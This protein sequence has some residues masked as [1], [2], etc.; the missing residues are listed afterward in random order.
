MLRKFSNRFKTAKVP[1]LSF[2]GAVSRTKQAFKKDADINFIMKK[3]RETGLLPSVRDRKPFYGDFT[4]APDFLETQNRI[5][6][7]RQYFQQLPADVRDR[8]A[9]DPARMLDFLANPEN[10]AE[11]VKLGLK[12]A[13]KAPEAPVEPN[14]PAEKPV[15]AAVTPPVGQ[16]ST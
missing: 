7:T 5:A 3:Y 10:D 12:E 1:G 11:A 6:H 14:K 9:N 8:F 2:D 15:E 4:N 16:S 13:P